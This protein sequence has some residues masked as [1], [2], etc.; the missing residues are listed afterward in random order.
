MD[1]N[2]LPA[3]PLVRQVP[4]VGRYGGRFVLGQTVSPKTFNGMMATETSSSDITNLI[5]TSLVDFDNAT[6]EFGPP[7]RHGVGRV[8]RRHDLDVPPPQGRSVF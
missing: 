6:Q 4:S 2:P 1:P 7:A 8:A 5:F 3:E